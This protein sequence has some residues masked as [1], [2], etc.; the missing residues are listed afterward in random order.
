LS[1][2]AHLSTQ[3]RALSHASV[4]GSPL[5][6]ARHE[7]FISARLI[8]AACAT[9]SV[10]MFILFGGVPTFSQATAFAFMML[11]LLSVVALSRTGNILLAQAVSVASMVGFASALVAGANVPVEAGIAWLVLIPIESALMLEGIATAVA[12]IVALVTAAI[13]AFGAR[14]GV[15]PRYEIGS[16]LQIAFAIPAIVYA[17]WIGIAT[18]RLSDISRQT[19][20]NQTVDYKALA[21][22]IGDL[23]VR[24]DRFGA[25]MRASQDGIALFDLAPQELSGRGLFERIHV[26]DRPLYLKTMSDA[27]NSSSTVAAIMRLRLGSLEAEA[28]GDAPKFTWI[29]MRARALNVDATDTGDV[30]SSHIEIV[31]VLRDVS[32]RV[33]R[34]T[35]IEHARAETELTAKWKDRFLANVSH[36]LR[37]PLN[38]IIGFSDMLSSE[39]LCPTDPAKV[40]EYAAIV[41]NSGQHL[42]EVV[43]TILDMSKIE[44]GNY[45]MDAE[46]FAIAQMV[47]QTCDMVRLRAESNNVTLVRQLDPN[48]VEMN[49]DKRSVKQIL[50][51]LVSNAV[52]FTPAG[53]SVQVSTRPDGNHIL[54]EVADNGIGID[55]KDLNRLG[56]PFF[57]A[58]ASH[59]RSHEGTGLGL[60]VVRGLVGLHNGRISVESEVGR[61]TRVTVRLPL[62]S[63]AHRAKANEMAKIEVLA[64]Y[65]P[66]IAGRTESATEDQAP[67]Q[68]NERLRNRA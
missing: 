62:D 21:D 40:R 36:E 5:E 6:R 11:P 29:E 44:S 61:G 30:P 17:I 7:V 35:E 19:L 38:A 49:A 56:S 54:L 27:A 39:E 67:R 24:A 12:G 41:R 16:S 51:N 15:L 63:S 3:I 26:A 43:N 2:T 13:L 65:I 18:V 1:I 46:P 45:D 22:A 52:K 14:Y 10:P 8:G 60:S 68:D 42:L 31:A 4:H 34:E 57:Q 59:S 25:V 20:K 53:G 66:S 37:T 64:R 23:V 28:H 55:A 33:L 50:L 48:L 32:D 9:A 58:S 47:E